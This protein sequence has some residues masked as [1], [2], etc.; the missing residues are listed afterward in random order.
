MLA[1]WSNRLFR[2]AFVVLLAIPPAVVLWVTARYAVFVPNGHYLEYVP[3]S[4]SILRNG[5][6]SLASLFHT[7]LEHP[8]ISYNLMFAGFGMLHPA[9]LL[10]SV[11]SMVLST[12]ASHVFAAVTA[13]LL[14]RIAL[15]THDT[16]HPWMRGILLLA[17]VAVLFSPVQWIIWVEPFIG[18]TLIP[19]I[20]VGVIVLLQGDTQSWIRF[21]IAVA[22][23][24]FASFGV[25]AGLAVWPAALPVL[26]VKNRTK[27]RM[28]MILSWIG[29]AAATLWVF[30]LQTQIVL[31]TGIQESA[32]HRFPAF[33]LILLGSSWSTNWRI[34]EILGLVLCLSVVVAAW[35]LRGASRRAAPWIGI[36][37]FAI[38]AAVLVAYGRFPFGKDY[39]LQPRYLVFTSIGWVGIA[40]LYVL[41]CRR[42]ILAAG[43]MVFMIVFLVAS[44]PRVHMAYASHHAIWRQAAACVDIYSIASDA[45]LGIL[46]FGK[47]HADRMRKGAE[48]SERLGLWKAAGLPPPTFR[49]GADAAD[50]MLEEASVMED[51]QTVRLK[52]WAVLRGCPADHV[53]VTVGSAR[54]FIGA[55]SAVFERKD[56]A[57]AGGKPCM[58]T[59]G[60]GLLIDPVQS[61]VMEGDMLE[62]WVWDAERGFLLPAGHLP[63]HPARWVYPHA[64][65]ASSN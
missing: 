16:V 51:G 14:G 45:C 26:W 19:A 62:V 40:Y 46:V 13:I 53:Y 7:I 25:A 6:P 52:G 55:T 63:Y 9:L 50:G 58:R 65:R 57:D 23:A 8:I 10:P 33:I 22:L 64:L 54:R 30:L 56:V 42:K 1:V 21:V 44:W 20:A 61:K 35:K 59:A 36:V 37:V 48:Q 24:V 4:E 41:A 32:W 47:Q 60:W 43:F 5:Y 27:T 29:L 3:L 28:W 12:Y 2:F 39:A 38:A 15:R 18:F 34:A 31:G 17:T 11:P 49:A